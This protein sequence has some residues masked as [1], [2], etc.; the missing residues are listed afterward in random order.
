VKKDVAVIIKA[1]TITRA[2]NRY[3]I[4]SAGCCPNTVVKK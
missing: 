4:L 2:S 1:I 3:F